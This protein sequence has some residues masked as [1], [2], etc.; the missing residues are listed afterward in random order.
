MMSDKRSRHDGD[1]R[2]QRS[3]TSY[4]TRSEAGASAASSSLSEAR[5]RA[6][7]SKLQ[8]EQGQRAAAAKA[9][10]ARQEAEAAQRKAELER[11]EAATQA[12]AARRKAELAR[13]QTE[14]QAAVEAQELKDKAER[15]QLE[16]QLLE[17]E[18]GGSMPTDKQHRPP[19]AL[20]QLQTSRSCNSTSCRSRTP[21]WHAPGSG[22]LSYSRRHAQRV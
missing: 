22:C 16:L 1:A 18:E 3:R 9:E 17:Q 6:A 11:Q 5:R 10:L 20:R 14:A 13:K 12:E 4:R 15:C 21:Q 19:K 8:A 7:L 2:S